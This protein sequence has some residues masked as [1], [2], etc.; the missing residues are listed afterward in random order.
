MAKLVLR[1]EYMPRMKASIT[2]AMVAPINSAIQARV[3]LKNAWSS[4]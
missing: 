4:W 2:K 3:W 1:L